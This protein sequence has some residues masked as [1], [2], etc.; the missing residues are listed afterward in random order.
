[1]LT[2]LTPL[3]FARRA[4]KLYGNREAVVDGELSF[5]EVVQALHPH[6]RRVAREASQ[7]TRE[8][9]TPQETTPDVGMQG[10]RACP[11]TGRVD[12]EHLAAGARA[13]KGCYTLAKESGIP[14]ST[15]YNRLK[16]M[17]VLGTSKAR[18]AI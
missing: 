7:A 3:D 4:R 1:M 16:R 11:E 2:P 9:A 12:W 8:T 5:R 6:L 14:Q 17:G 13:G 18:V 10:P 15:I